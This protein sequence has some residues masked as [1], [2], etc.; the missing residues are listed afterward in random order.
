M[1]KEQEEESIDHDRVPSKV[2]KTGSL[3]KV[4]VVAGTKC[5]AADSVQFCKEGKERGT[6]WEGSEE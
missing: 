3:P 1:L 5:L 2:E 6:K 4:Y